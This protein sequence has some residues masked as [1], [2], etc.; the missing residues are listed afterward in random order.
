MRSAASY[1][2]SGGRFMTRARRRP[3]ARGRARRGGSGNERS[4]SRGI[5]I[6]LALCRAVVKARRVSLARRVHPLLILAIVCAGYSATLTAPFVF[7]DPLVMRTPSVRTLSWETVGHTTRP[8]VQLSLALNHAQGGTDVVGFHVVN[9]LVHVLGALALLGVAAHTLAS[10][11]FGPELRARAPQLALVIALIWVIHPL[12]TESVTY[13][14]QRAESLTGLFYLLMLYCV[15]RGAASSRAPAWY[16]GAVA[17]CA[18]GMLA[19][20]VMV[21]APLAVLAYDSVFLAG[22]WRAALRQRRALYVGLVATWIILVALLGGGSHESAGSAG[23][24]IRDLTVGE[25]L[26]SQPGVVLRYLRLVLWPHGLVLD[27]GWLPAEGFLG[28]VIPTVALAALLAWPCWIFR[29]HPV[30]G[31]MVLAFVALLAPSSSVIPIKDLAVEH[32]MYLALAPLIALATIGG[33]E[34]IQAA[35]FRA[36]VARRVAAG[37]AVAVLAVLTALTIDRN[38]DYRSAIAMWT[39]VVEKRPANARGHGNLGQAQFNGGEIAAAVVSLRTALRLDPEYPEA[40]GNLGLALTA[41]G[42]FDEAAAAYIA[43]L[44]LDPTRV[45]TQSNYGNLLTREGNFGAAVQQYRAA[46]LTD[47][48]YAEVHFNLAVALAGQGKRDE[49][50]AQAAE[51]LRLRPDLDAVFRPSGLLAA[52]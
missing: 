13:V 33:W 37:T 51:A 31:C 1:N 5:E 3:R 8:L 39:D 41:Q 22:G 35:G 21:T 42:R 10:K 6:T 26:G 19:K 20:P 4:Q 43:S 16:A 45:E 47:P 32:R 38:H 30:V 9:L 25:Y 17:A 28:I 46:L 50:V 52:R 14:V 49:A 44:R 36:V 40:Y 12:Q 24:A 15:I 7:D 29:A 34:A 18:L 2:H 23:Y 27:Y 48:G 11:R